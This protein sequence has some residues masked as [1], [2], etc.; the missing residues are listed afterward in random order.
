MRAARR[1]TALSWLSIDSTSVSS[2][3]HSAN[4]PSTVRTGDSGK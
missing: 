4:L 2:T 3:T 1:A